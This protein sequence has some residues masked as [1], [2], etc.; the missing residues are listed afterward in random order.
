MIAILLTIWLVCA[1]LALLVQSARASQA[2]VDV[3]RLQ[4]NAAVLE[5][6]LRRYVAF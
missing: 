5:K 2:E 4:R 6:E 1:L 3:K